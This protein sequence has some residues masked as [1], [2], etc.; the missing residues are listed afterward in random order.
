VTLYACVPARDLRRI[1]ADGFTAGD[2]TTSGDQ[3]GVMLAASPEC[4]TGY[5]EPGETEHW[6]VSVTLPAPAWW[7]APYLDPS[8]ILATYFVPAHRLR[9]ARIR[10]ERIAA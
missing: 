7:L 10:P 1:L 6:L 2:E 3:I 5:P 8:W 4:W 9:G